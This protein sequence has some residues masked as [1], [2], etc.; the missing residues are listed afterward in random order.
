MRQEFEIMKVF[1]LHNR[2]QFICARQL[3][4]GQ[5]FN[6]KE[7]SLLG[8]VPIDHYLEMPR[9]LDENGQPRLDVFVFRPLSLEKFPADFFKEGQLV[10]LVAPD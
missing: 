7:G 10:E 6:V 2:G 5:N 9:M 8:G 3:N 4:P 1:D